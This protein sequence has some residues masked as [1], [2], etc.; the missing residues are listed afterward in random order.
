MV[1]FSWAVAALFCLFSGFSVVRA[2][3][4]LTGEVVSLD[5]K[6]VFAAE[7]SRY[8]VLGTSDA[9]GARAYGSVLTDAMGQFSLPL[10]QKDLPIDVVIYA[11]DRKTAAVVH[12]STLSHQD[13]IVLQPVSKV[14]VRA[15]APGLGDKLEGPRFLLK[16]SDGATLGQL[17]GNDVEFPFPPGMYDLSLSSADTVSTDKP[18][19][20][21]AGRL[22]PL[23]F[24][25]QLSP[26]AKRFGKQPPSLTG[27]VDASNRAAVLPKFD[28]PTLVYF[29]AD[30][31]QP[32]VAEGIPHLL[33]FANDHKGQR[34]QIIAVHE[35][36][37]PTV[38]T[39]IAF[40]RSLQ[41][42]QQ[43]VWKQDLSFPFVFD[44]TGAVTAAWGLSTFPTYALVDGQG[45]LQRE[46]SVEQLELLI[47]NQGN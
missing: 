41:H 38:S 46:A 9:N 14:H 26:M 42:L 45:K 7:V 2:Q 30:W 1:K 28:R 39:R 32:C 25:L 6:P 11:S 22:L 21:A 43:S 16:A 37:I 12:A 29:W 3:S 4:T 13:K 31:C 27:L 5:G 35:N 40:Q 44:S 19:H 33:Q 8:W 34:F 47:R 10:E 20:I 17:F 18:V 24:T 36:G 23:R 15:E